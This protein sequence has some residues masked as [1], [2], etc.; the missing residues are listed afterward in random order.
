MSKDYRNQKDALL[1]CIDIS[2]SML[3]KSEDSGMS[4]A[5]VALESAYGV[6]QERIISSY[7][8][9]VGIMLYGTKLQ[10]EKAFTG[11]YMLLDLEIPDAASI[12]RIKELLEGKSID[13]FRSMFLYQ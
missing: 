8:D 4:A 13:Q 9:V 12:R 7:K 5:K 11:C 10:S 6:L 1:F 3:M 2:T